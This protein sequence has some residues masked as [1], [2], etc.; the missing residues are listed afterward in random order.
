MKREIELIK[1]Q[2]PIKPEM[3]Y[4]KGGT[5]QMGSNEDDSSK[6][7]HT[8]TVDNFY[9]GKYEVT[10]K[11]YCEFLNSAGN[12]EEGERTWI[13]GIS[14]HEYVGIIQK[15]DKFIVKRGYEYNPVVNITWYGAVAYCNWLSDRE[16]LVKCYG[17]K[18]NR[19]EGDIKKKGYRLPTEAEW[20]YACRAGT[21]T[22]YYWGNEIDGSYCWYGDNRDRGGCHHKVGLLLPNGYNLYDM[23]GNVSEWCNDW[24]DRNYYS[25]SPSNNPVGPSSGSSRVIRGGKYSDTEKCKSASR[26]QFEPDQCLYYFGFR[27]ARTP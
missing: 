17:E 9:I 26:H 25:Q 2:K 7:V 24:Y 18:D 6:P 3:V 15:G 14:G 19:G 22:E 21:T 5:F 20:E 10:N 8:V 4:I 27:S 16:G 11:E 1:K 13:R 12:Q 23:S